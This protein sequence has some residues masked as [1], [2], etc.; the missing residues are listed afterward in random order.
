MKGRTRYGAIVDVHSGSV[1][2]AIVVL[3]GTDVPEVIFT[4]REY[5]KVE[6][7]TDTAAKLRA[8]KNALFTASLEYAQSGQ[9]ALREYDPK[10]RVTEVLLVYG[11]PWAITS[12]RFIR[13]EEEAPFVVTEER[14]KALIAEAE[15]ADEEEYQATAELKERGLAIIERSVIH[16]MLNGYRISEP[17]G[18]KATEFSL[19]HISGLIPSALESMIREVEDKVIPHAH[20]VSHTFALVLFCVV[21]DL[22]PSVPHGVLI[23]ISGEATEVMIVQDEVLRESRTF[24]YGTHT[25]LRDVAKTLATYPDEALG[26]IREYGENSPEAVKLAITNATKAYSESLQGIFD[27]LKTRFVLP[28]HFF[29]STSKNLDTFFED[30]VRKASESH[31]GPHGMLVSLN[32]T[33]RTVDNV[34]PKKPYDAF[35]AVESRFFQKRHACGEIDE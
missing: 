26:H 30:I 24:P 23:D 9:T 19:A 13:I 17:Y 34:D 3:E 27:E 14:I 31:I 21:R 1:G 16:T 15:K 22:Y 29:L 2:V 33:L 35:F 20:H 7:H 4:H 18:K 6:E 5:L 8:L 32:T 12:T 28:H 10:G 11:A 25:F